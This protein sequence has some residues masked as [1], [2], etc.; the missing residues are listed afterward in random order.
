MKIGFL[1]SLIFKSP[2]RKFVIDG[3]NANFL[4]FLTGMEATHAPTFWETIY[5]SSSSG[6]KN[7][8]RTPGWQFKTHSRRLTSTSSTLLKGSRVENKTCS[9]GLARAL[10]LYWWLMMS[11]TQW[12][13]ETRERSC[14]LAVANTSLAYHLTISQVNRASK[15]GLLK[16]EAKFTSKYFLG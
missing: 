3:P 16:Q 7:F 5:I 8:H 12:M 13:W 1:S 15:N 2:H 11:A 10:S 4:P 6:I 9:I 14:R